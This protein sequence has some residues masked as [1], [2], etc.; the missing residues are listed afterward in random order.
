PPTLEGVFQ[1]PVVLLPV[2]PAARRLLAARF[3]PGDTFRLK[4]KRRLLGALGSGTG[5]SV[6]SFARIRGTA[7]S[8]GFQ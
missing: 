6:I 7:I 5:F 3:S 1:Q 4:A 2:L 8:A